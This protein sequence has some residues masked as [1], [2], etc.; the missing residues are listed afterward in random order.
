MLI[1]HQPLGSNHLK[2]SVSLEPADYLPQ[3]ESE[4]RSL[5]KKI[6]VPGFRPGKV[7]AGIT[8]KMYGNAVLFEVLNRI[9]SD[10]LHAYVK[11][12]QFHLF[13]E[14]IPVTTMQQQM[15]VETPTALVFDFEIGLVPDLQLPEPSSAHLVKRRLDVTDEMVDREVERLRLRYGHRTPVQTAAEGDVLVG[16][17]TELDAEGQPAAGGVHASASFSLRRI[18]DPET[19]A[20]LMQLKPEDSLTLNLLQAFGDDKEFLI[21]HLLQL[22]HDREAALQSPYRF[23]LTEIVR[24]EKA[25]LNQEFFD[26]VFG[27]G[28][29][30]SEEH[31]RQWLRAD[32]ENDSSRS[33]VSRLHADLRNFLLEHTQM[34]L[35]EA[36]I[37]RLL[38]ERRE[39]D[40][41]PLTDEQFPQALQQVKWEFIVSGIARQQQLEV[42]QEELQQEAQ[43]EVLNYFGVPADFFASEPERLQ[44]LTDSVLARPENRRR[45]HTRCLHRKVLEWYTAKTSI[46]EQTVSEEEF[47]YH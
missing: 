3:V 5:S 29:V 21:H 26:R 22:D 42:T 40:E 8:R 14:P 4:I 44:R 6:S 30:T 41:P 23:S 47:F 35:P 2:I 31:M 46:T 13:G 10:R 1:T 19:A 32:L 12:Q 11:E 27:A 16:Q 38:D 9:V 45:L 28:R 25:E 20:R 24:I 37:R 39:P 34:D 17:F 15:D 33:S 36:F 18:K 7:P 43:Q